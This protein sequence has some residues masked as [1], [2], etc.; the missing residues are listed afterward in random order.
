[1]G[2]YSIIK[3][4][5]AFLEKQYGFTID[6]QQK[7]GSYYFIVWK[8]ERIAIKPLYDLVDKPHMRILTYDADSLG[9]AYDVTE[10][11]EEFALGS[12]TPHERIHLAAEW[13]A[14]AIIEGRIGI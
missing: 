5:F 1:M 2:I 3:R 7:H 14:K 9:T 6:L 11:W 4:E 8:N 12:G 10:Y 13:L